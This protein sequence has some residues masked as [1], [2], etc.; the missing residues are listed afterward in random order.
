M[1]AERL[2]EIRVGV[3][4]T[5]EDTTRLADRCARQL[6]S[7]SLPYQLSVTGQEQPTGPEA[8]PL[9]ESYEDLLSSGGTGTPELTPGLGA[10]T[11]SGS[12]C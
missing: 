10:S 12:V 7:H 11:K 9:A 6:D 1:P 5:E 3:Y 8:M 4:A 2:F